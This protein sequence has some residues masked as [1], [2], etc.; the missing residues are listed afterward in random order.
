MYLK[1]RKGDR[2]N[3]LDEYKK[4]CKSDEFDYFYSNEVKIDPIVWFYEGRT[5]KLLNL[6]DE[7]IL[8]TEY[9]YL[10]HKE[11]D[12]TKLKYKSKKCKEKFCTMYKYRYNSDAP[13]I[14]IYGDSYLLGL[15]PS[16]VYSFNNTLCIFEYML[17]Y[18]YRYALRIDVHEDKILKNKPQI[19]VI[20]LSEIER[21]KYLYME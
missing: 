14:V 18:K 1:Y 13:N 21:L 17:S 19:L 2:M 11:E 16:I 20:C 7:S 8:D 4:W 5:Y 9:K 10:I 6:N 15:M 3:Y 12:K